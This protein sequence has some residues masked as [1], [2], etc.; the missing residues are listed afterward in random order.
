LRATGSSPTTRRVSSKEWAVPGEE[1]IVPGEEG[2]SEMLDSLYGLL[3][4]APEGLAR[5]ELARRALR[6][7][8]RGGPASALAAVTAEITRVLEAD[9]RFRLEPPDRWRLATA[10]CPGGGPFDPPAGTPLEALTFAVVDLETTGCAPPRDRIIEVGGAKV[11]AGRIVERYRQLVH[12]GRPIPPFVTRLTGIDDA[13]VD[14]APPFAQVADAVRAF[15]DGCVVVAHNAAFDG[16]F[17][18]AELAAAT[19]CGLARPL[20]CTV[21]VG[22][23]LLAGT[24]T[25]FNLD[26]VADFYGLGFDGRHRA[27]GDAEVTALVLLR[28][29]KRCREEGIATWGDL[30]RL[31]N[32]RPRAGRGLSRAGPAAGRGPS[33][34][35]PAAGRGPSRAGPA[36][37]RGPSRAGPAAGRRHSS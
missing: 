26:T 36:A 23:R 30:W 35:G 2:T 27:L 21:R 37:G 12:P 13:M 18:E 20:L 3:A 15:V 7:A 11:A 17:L 10:A 8:G 16:R 19:G 34:A 33:R 32:S 9:P 28:F 22:R 24:L 31:T 1:G 25:R 6:L 4:R 5:E 14:E 29:L